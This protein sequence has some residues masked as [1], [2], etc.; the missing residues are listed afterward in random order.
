MGQYLQFDVFIPFAVWIVHW[1]SVV[2]VSAPIH[3]YVQH[4]TDTN[5]LK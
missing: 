3:L 1:N 4:W 5:R 2:F